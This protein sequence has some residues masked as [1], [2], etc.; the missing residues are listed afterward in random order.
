MRKSLQTGPQAPA[1]IPAASTKKRNDFKGRQSKGAD[2]GAGQSGLDVGSPEWS[3][4]LARITRRTVAT[5]DGCRVWTGAN[6]RNGLHGRI[7]WRGELVAPHRIVLENA[8]GRRLGRNEDACHHCDNPPCVRVEHLFAGTRSQNM[9]DASLK[10]R[11]GRPKFDY[12]IVKAVVR[13]SR[14]GRAHEELVKLY[15]VSHG[16]VD[17]FIKGQTRLSALAIAELDG[18]PYRHPS[19]SLKKFAKWLRP[20]ET[21]A[22]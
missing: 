21:D 19:A 20:R 3:A 11:L 6:G 14:A 7:K 16:T 5:P 1:S 13:E 22:A 18:T 8:L 12:E 9:L 15:G 4:L 10:G 2:K 17:H